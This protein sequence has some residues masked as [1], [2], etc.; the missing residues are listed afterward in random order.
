MKRKSYKYKRSYQWIQVVIALTILSRGFRI[1]LHL[2]SP[3]VENMVSTVITMIVFLVLGT[4]YLVSSV[5]IFIEG[6]RKIVTPYRHGVYQEIIGKAKNVSKSMFGEGK[7]DVF[8]I[9]DLHFEIVAFNPLP[10]YNRQAAYGGVDFVEEDEL[11][12]KYVM[13]SNELRIMELKVNPRNNE[14]NKR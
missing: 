13:Y 5:R 6:R 3:F 12:I 14:E 8:E 11:E 1:I 2:G 9:N 10:G 7:P 4:F